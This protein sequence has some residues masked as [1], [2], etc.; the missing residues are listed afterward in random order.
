MIFLLVSYVITSCQRITYAHVVAFTDAWFTAVLHRVTIVT[1]STSYRNNSKHKTLLEFRTGV[2]SQWYEKWKETI[3]SHNWLR[4]NLAY[5]NTPSLLIRCPDRPQ[6]S[7]RQTEWAFPADTQQPER[8][9]RRSRLVP[10][11]GAR[12]GLAHLAHRTSIITL[13]TAFTAVTGGVEPTV[14]QVT[15]ILL[16]ITD[17]IQ[18]CLICC[19]WLKRWSQSITKSAPQL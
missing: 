10:S 7:C 6:R 12:T 18:T 13:F 1:K 14:L 16:I 2:L 3:T 17:S 8:R 11:G 15:T 9:R 4:C 19:G 5:T